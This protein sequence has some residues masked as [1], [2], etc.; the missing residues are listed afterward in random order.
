MKKTTLSQEQKC[1]KCGCTGNQKK[2]GF[3]RSGTQRCEC[4]ECG[5]TYTIDPKRHDYPED[6]RDAAI[7]AYYSGATGRGVGRQFGMSKANVYN[8]IKKTK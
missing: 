1:P 4:K 5:G 8:W 7:R 3:N 6:V 2:K